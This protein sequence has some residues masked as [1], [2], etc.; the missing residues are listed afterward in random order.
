MESNNHSWQC[1][2]GDDDG[3]EK[4]RR[5]GGEESSKG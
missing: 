4:A 2:D 1:Q 3:E 5:H